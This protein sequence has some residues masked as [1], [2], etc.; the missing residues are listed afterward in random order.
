MGRPL[1]RC[2]EVFL[3]QTKKV[4]YSNQLLTENTQL[5]KEKMDWIAYV[6]KHQLQLPEWCKEKTQ[7]PILEKSLT[8]ATVY[9][10]DA[11]QLEMEALTFS[12]TIQTHVP[13]YPEFLL[14]D[15]DDSDTSL[16]GPFVVNYLMA[17]E[18]RLREQLNIHEELMNHIHEDS[19]SEGEQ[20]ELGIEF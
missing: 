7:V 15:E 4:R 18:D 12:E 17:N 19:F 2:F 1:S 20:D 16:N 5:Q 3:I 8:E 9:E 13:E 6:K 11:D 10:N 14:F